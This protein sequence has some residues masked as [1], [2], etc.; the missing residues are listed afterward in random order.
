M[1]RQARQLLLRGDA[2]QRPGRAR[3]QRPRSAH[4][5]VEAGIGRGDPDIERLGHGAEPLGDGPGRGERAVEAFGQ[6]R[7]AVDRDHMMRPRR[8]KA[9][10][11][12]VVGAAA[13]VKHRAAA[14]VAMR[15]DKLGDRRLDAGL[16]Q[17]LDDEAA[18]P[19]AVGSARPMLQGAAAADAEMRADRRDALGARLFDGE[20]LPA[21]RM[22]GPILDFD[23][24]ARQ[25][26]RHIDRTVGAG[27]DAV[28]AL[29]DRID[30]QMLNHVRP[31]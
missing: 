16:V 2:R 27:R 15:V 13:G 28:A 20:E 7:T 1:A 19:G 25:R 11:E 5:D 14:A 30:F 23:A 6:N 24:F 8:R 18:L 12:H 10:F 26:A 3:G 21:V 9:D 29:A 17:R 31:R 4:V 22:A